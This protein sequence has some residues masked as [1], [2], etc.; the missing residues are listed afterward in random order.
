MEKIEFIRRQITQIQTGG[1]EV[2]A[3]KIKLLSTLMVTRVVPIVIYLIPAFCLRV[4]NF[5]FPNFLTARIGH[6]MSEPDCYLKEER[7]GLI[8]KRMIIMLSPNNQVANQSVIRY[9]SQHFFVIKNK[10][11]V[12]LLHPLTSHPLSRV[13]VRR[14]NVA[15][16]KSAEYCKIQSL[17]SDRPP[18][19]R[20]TQDDNYRGQQALADI[21]IPPD[22][23]FV[24]FHSR[25]D[26][27]SPSDENFNSFR[28]FSFEDYKLAIEYISAKGGICIAMGDSSM[29]PI[30]HMNNV[31]D[32]AHHPIRNDS[33]D[34]YLAANCRLFLGNS[35]GAFLM[36]SV[37]GVPVACCNIVPF[38]GVFVFGKKDIAIPK[39]YKETASGRLLPFKEILDSPMANFRYSS[40]YES[41]GIELI[42]N[43]PEDIMALALEQFEISNSSDFVYSEEDD[44]LQL[45]FRELFKPGHYSYGSASRVGRAFLKRYQHL[46]P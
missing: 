13:D 28:N 20:I 43:S 34:L 1:Y 33:L 5:R 42:N 36:A 37:F 15:V 21:G 16:N 26:G 14:Y 4:L 11:I 7:L 31:I 12:K 32:Y 24:C 41:A 3:R 6:L 46:L 10:L 2:F 39:L 40:H 17:W 25:D 18:L 9:W 22:A 23:W 8:P 45:R 29:Q 44:A 30:S 35:S 19:L 38:S 27:Y